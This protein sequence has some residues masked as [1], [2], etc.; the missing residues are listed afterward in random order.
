MPLIAP[1]QLIDAQLLADTC[2]AINAT[3]D[4]VLARLVESGESFKAARVDTR[5]FHVKLAA[6]GRQ[7]DFETLVVSDIPAPPPTPDPEP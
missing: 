2:A 4:R 7:I 6:Q 3:L 1:A 5:P